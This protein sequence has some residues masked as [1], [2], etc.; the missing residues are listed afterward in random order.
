MGTETTDPEVFI[1]ES[2]TRDDFD[3][4]RCEGD[5][6]TRILKMG[7]RSPEYFYTQTFEEFH[8]ALVAFSESNYRYLH[9]SSHGASDHFLFQFGEVYFNQ[10]S[11]M[12]R[13]FLSHKR[14]FVSACEAVSHDNHELANAV[15]RNTGCYSLIGSAEPIDFDDA[16]MFWSTFYYLAYQNQGEKTKFNRDLIVTQLRKL[17]DLYPLKINYYSYSQSQ[18]IKL[19]RFA[20]GKKKRL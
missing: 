14:I 7:G 15:L 6:I 8:Q 2:L 18:G 3:N 5:I 11:G 9:I 4:G 17:T 13:D 20:E 16:A 10:F 12:V 19:D 1:I